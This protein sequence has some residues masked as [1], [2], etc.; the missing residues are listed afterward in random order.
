MQ[1]QQETLPHIRGLYDFGFQK[2]ATQKAE[3]FPM[4]W[5]TAQLPPLEL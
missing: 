2:Y 3:S 5:Q 4:Y 1:E